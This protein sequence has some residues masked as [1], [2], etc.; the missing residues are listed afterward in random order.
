MISD[1]LLFTG[2]W[3][4]FLFLCFL[5]FRMQ[6]IEHEFS[7][8][9]IISIINPTFTSRSFVC[10]TI[11]LLNLIYMYPFFIWLVIST[12][13]THFLIQGF[14]FHL[15]I[16]VSPESATTFSIRCI[17]SILG[18]Q[19]LWVIFINGQNFDLDNLHSFYSCTSWPS[20]S[21]SK[22]T[23]GASPWS[24]VIAEWESG[25]KRLS[26][27]LSLLESSAS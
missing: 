15:F 20:L 25:C 12:C 19:V 2:G 9:M 6:P 16:C 27:D 4:C 26:V 14:I 23:T 11:S 5:L 18:T 13:D 22:H 7:F 10:E 1:F 17:Y 8:F 24:S 21:L 3:I